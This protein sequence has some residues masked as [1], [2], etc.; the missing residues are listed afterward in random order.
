MTVTILRGGS[1]SLVIANGVEILSI[2]CVTRWGHKPERWVVRPQSGRDGFKSQWCFV[3]ERLM[4][5][6]RW[7]HRHRGY[8]V[9]GTRA[10][11][12]LQVV[13]RLAS[14]QK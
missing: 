2:D 10:K 9:S 7:N 1:D 11:R 6:A 4:G 12:I 5:A 13:A 8:I 14:R 3:V